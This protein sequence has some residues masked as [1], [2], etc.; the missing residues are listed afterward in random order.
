M[1]KLLSAAG[2]YDLKFHL[3]IEIDN[4]VPAEVV[5][6]LNQLL[7]DVNDRFILS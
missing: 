1:G 7:N 3:R 2:E 6:K 5:D 4:E